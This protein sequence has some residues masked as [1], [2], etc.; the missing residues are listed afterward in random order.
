MSNINILSVA[1]RAF[2]ILSLSCLTCLI[3]NHPAS[4][5]DSDPIDK[6]ESPPKQAND[7]FQRTN[8]VVFKFNDKLY[9]WAIKPT[10]IAYKSVFPQKIRE[11]VA[12]AAYNLAFPA[13]FVNNILQ[14]KG[15]RADIEMKRFIIN[16]TVGL[17]GFLDPAA[18]CYG[19]D[20]PHEE[21]FGQTLALWGVGTGPFLMAPVLGPSDARDFIG[22]AV[23]K[24]MD[25][26]EWIPMAIWV[27]PGVKAGN[28]VN[29]ASLKLGTYEDFK[30]S[31]ID[32][33]IS[34][35]D[36]YLQHREYATQQ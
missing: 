35:R 5:L 7:P 27:D 28:L 17:G 24:A 3:P 14:R 13:R 15:E 18:D 30:A 2:F 22:Y 20:K 21:D 31:A 10:A 1:T 8:R 26:L 36:A 32:P 11:S 12:K 25:P 19:L 34:L 9:S 16:S 23:D 6:E 4:A 29:S 33:Y